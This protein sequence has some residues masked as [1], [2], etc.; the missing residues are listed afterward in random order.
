MSPNP[1]RSPDQ[2]ATEGRVDGS[3]TLYLGADKPA[4]APESN[5]IPTPK[6]TGYSLTFRFYRPKGAVADRAYFPPALKEQ[7]GP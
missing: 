1:I 4:N 2:P 5:W 6:G 3:L 7:Q